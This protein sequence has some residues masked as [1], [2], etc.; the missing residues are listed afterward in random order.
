[1]QTLKDEIRNRIIEAAVNEF[2]LN[3]YEKASMRDISRAAGTSVS[4]T[5]NYYKNKQELFENLIRPVYETVRNIF[6]Q[7]LMQSVQQMA[8]G[9]NQMAFIE[10]IAGKLVAMD[11]RQRRLFI[12]LAENSAGTGYEKAKA[13]MTGLLR[14]QLAEAVRRPGSSVQ[15]EENRLYILNIIAESYMDG[16][17]K[18]LKDYRDQA[19]AEANIRTLLAVHLNGIKA[20]TG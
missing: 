10:Y 18:I 15:M 11:A 17:L 5:Y 6:R 13:E 1:M 3:G 4:N 2:S 14:M 19:W 9:G 7:S 12:V 16:L 8:A 20:L